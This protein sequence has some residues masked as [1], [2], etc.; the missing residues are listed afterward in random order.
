VPGRYRVEREIGR[1]GMGEVYPARGSRLDRRGAL[2]LL[3]L[4]RGTQT[5]DVATVTDFK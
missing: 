4:A 2:K 1:G 3:A 5:R